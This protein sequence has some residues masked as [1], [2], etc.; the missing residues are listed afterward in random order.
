MLLALLALA[1]TLV[2]LG[3]AFESS[4]TLFGDRV[5]ARETAIAGQALRVALWA[6]ATPL[7]AVAVLRRS[8]AAWLGAAVWLGLLALS[9]WWRWPPAPTSELDADNPLWHSSFLILWA[10]VVAGLVA[11]LYAGLRS[12]RRSVVAISIG[13]AAATVALGGASHVNL[14]RHANEERPVPLAEGRAELA[15]LTSDPFW[16]ALPKVAPSY[17]REQGAARAVW[18]DRLTTHRFVRLGTVEDRRLFR[19]VVAAAESTGWTL[20]KTHCIGTAW[21]ATF[22]KSLPVG[23]ATLWINVASYTDG[24]DVSARVEDSRVSGNRVKC[25]GA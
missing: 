24:V 12:R 18:G 3:K 21:D 19:D 17:E 11:G 22:V 20:D 9:A 5:T 25:W 14:T 16:A 15:A 4:L 10:L 13:L 8:R 23:S 6:I 1:V 7:C 2:A